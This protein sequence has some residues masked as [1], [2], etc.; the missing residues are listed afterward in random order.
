MNGRARCLVTLS[1]VTL[2]VVNVQNGRA[3]EWRGESTVDLRMSIERNPNYSATN[4]GNRHMGLSRIFGRLTT[5]SES[6]TVDVTADWTRQ[7][8]SGDAL[9]DR[10]EYGVRMVGN[11]ELESS[12]FSYSVGVSRDTLLVGDIE[13]RQFVLVRKW[14]T[15]ENIAP[16]IRFDL[17]PFTTSS[18]GL[19]LSQVT[20]PESRLSSL[21]DYRNV[22][23]DWSLQ[24][25]L[26]ERIGG[27][28]SAYATHLSTY[29]QAGT[30]G[31]VG[32]QGQLLIA[33]SRK[34]DLELSTGFHRVSN[35]AF[36]N[37]ESRFGWLVSGRGVAETATGGFSASISRS[38][39]PGGNGSLIQKDQIDVDFH[40]SVNDLFTLVIN[41]QAGRERAW[42]IGGARGLNRVFAVLSTRLSREISRNFSL[43]FGNEWNYYAFE[44]SPSSVVR[45]ALFGQ[46]TYRP[47]SSQLKKRENK[48]F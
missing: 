22:S 24:T 21:I 20:Y 11:K 25:E 38:V 35:S 7:N 28:L 15:S 31:D 33:L 29:G 42:T 5:E 45:T 27:Q 1:V 10:D 32:T 40:R 34:H 47:N 2:S 4:P 48:V 18:I 37:S 44:S 46:L 17:T 43:S 26:T 41:S 14:R 3:D 39:V 19:G 30:S 36:A 16:R 13:N 8:Y 9:L 23:A 12:T 6:R